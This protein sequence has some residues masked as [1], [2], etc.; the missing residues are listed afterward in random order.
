MKRKLLT[1]LLAGE[2]GS[3]GIPKVTKHKIQYMDKDW[4]EHV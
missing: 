2:D 3:R 4:F 1:T